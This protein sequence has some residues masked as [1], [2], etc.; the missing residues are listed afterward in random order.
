VQVREDAKDIKVGTVIALMV[1][2]GEDWKSVEVPKS[3][4]VSSSAPSPPPS[5]PASKPGSGG[6]DITSYLHEH[7]MDS[8]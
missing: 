1:A 3:S 5:E 4:D 7:E 8:S 2:E 6:N